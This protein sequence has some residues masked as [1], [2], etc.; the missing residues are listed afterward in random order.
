MSND[1]TI[2]FKEFDGPLDLLLSLLDEKKMEISEVSISKVTE[3]FLQYLDSLEEVNPQELADFLVVA[4]KL[5]FLKSKTL[6]PE[7]GTDEEDGMKLED[8][9]RLYRQFIE[10]SKQVNTLWMD[11]ARNSYGRIDP[12]VLIEGFF[13]SD[14]LKVN[15]LHKA[16]TEL[17]IRLAPPK[18]LPKTYID[19]SVSMKEKIDTIRNLLGSR[20]K[21]SFNDI[22]SDAQ[23]KTEVIVSF[24]ALLELVKQ[25]SIHIEQDKAFG[26]LQLRA[27]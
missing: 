23:S 6:L 25:R 18:A 9:L 19:K 17:V 10:V 2:Q 1:I 7:F 26:D 4:A 3:P 12:P 5:L 13:P 27:I 22:L 8:Q 15:N 16:M 14:N 24:L 11:E 21:L 20:K